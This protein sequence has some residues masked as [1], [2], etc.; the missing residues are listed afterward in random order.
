MCIFL[1]THDGR[2]VERSFVQRLTKVRDKLDGKDTTV[3]LPKYAFIG[4][5]VNLNGSIAEVAARL[6][7]SLANMFD[8]HSLYLDR[9]LM[10]AQ[11]RGFELFGWRHDEIAP[12]LKMCAEARVV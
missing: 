7:I 8:G 3:N 5:R 9:L 11:R 4:S 12:G 6:L 2:K 10:V 1:Y